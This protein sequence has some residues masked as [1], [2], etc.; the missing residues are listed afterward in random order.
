M[1]QK[2]PFVF[3]LLSSVL[4][5]STAFSVGCKN[6]E[7]RSFAKNDAN[8]GYNG[9]PA[10]PET[11]K[12]TGDSYTGLTVS[13]YDMYAFTS[14]CQAPAGVPAGNGVAVAEGVFGLQ[15]QDNWVP[16]P[17]ADDPQDVEPG[18]IKD[19]N[20]K[21]FKISTKRDYLEE[22]FK[23]CGGRCVKKAGEG[24]FLINLPRCNMPGLK[25]A[26]DGK[27]YEISTNMG[28]GSEKVYMHSVCPA[29]HWKNLAKQAFKVDDNHCSHPHID[30][31]TKMIGK[32]GLDTNVQSQLQVTISLSGSGGAAQPGGPSP[33]APSGPYGPQGGGSAGN[34]DPATGFP[35]CTNGSN[36]GNGYGWDESVT[37]PK[38]G[39]SC[40]PR[41]SGGNTGGFVPSGPSSQEPYSPPGDTQ[42][43]GVDPATGFPYC[44][45][46][47]NTGDGYG[48]DES[49]TDP[50]GAHSCVAR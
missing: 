36:T 23:M 28:K 3:A 46:G 43:G 27:I 10:A 24:K 13:F 17:N 20:A 38:G 35:Y 45:N 5:A 30:I 47:S 14:A 49:V 34:V 48:W 41:H 15:C 44:T 11:S 39:H 32:L 26:C 2:R 6:R 16:V 29:S 7:A 9:A 12:G 42:A 19:A 8:S 40:V 22:A 37:D 21:G 4:L 33:S 18:D 50:N 25:D 31:S 1:S